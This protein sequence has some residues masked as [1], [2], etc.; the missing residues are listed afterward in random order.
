MTYF[1]ETDIQNLEHL[2]KIN[3]INSCSGYKSANLIGS[4][5]KDRME[6]VAVFSISGGYGVVLVDLLENAGLTIPNF[7][8]E[9][10]KKLD[11][12]FFIRGTRSRNPLGAAA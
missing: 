9:I 3:L 2:Y 10:Q 11:E 6:N 4:K 7:S 12:Q 8:P 1:D 5:S